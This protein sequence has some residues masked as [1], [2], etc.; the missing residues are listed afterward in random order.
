MR[1]ESLITLIHAAP[2]KAFEM[3]VSDNR[4][5]VVDHPEFIA[6]SRSGRTVLVS[7]DPD[8]ENN[9]QTQELIDL[10]HVTSVT[11][12]IVRRSRPRRRRGK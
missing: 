12:D 1:A 5:F 7:A 2:F 9:F 4:S 8:D 3:H 6:V 10:I 11:L